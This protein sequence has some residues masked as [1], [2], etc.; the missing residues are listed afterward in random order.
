MKRITISI[1]AFTLITLLTSRVSFAQQNEETGKI[2]LPA[3]TPIKLVMLEQLYSQRNREGDE[4]LFMIEEDVEIMGK[5]YLVKGTPVLGRVVGS[6]QAKSWGRGG[7]IDIEITTIHPV[8]SMPIPLTGEAGERGGTDMAKSIGTTLILGVSVVG[9]LAGGKMTGKGAVIQPGTSVS[10]Y[11]AA[12]AEV[13]D[14]TADEMRQKVDDWFRDKTIKCTLNYAWGTRSTLGE[15][16]KKLGYSFDESKIEIE[17]MD[18][19]L[20]RITI[21]LQNE[22]S[23]IFILNPFEEPH[24]LKFI[25]LESEN[26]IAEMII[27]SVK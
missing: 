4:I 17:K 1:M 10:V 15:T 23:A 8:Y 26:E 3:G 13:M 24:A 19:Y 27:K 14:I 25:T 21:P 20:Y 6:K 2:I 7:S 11:S 22:Q 9:L 16:I 12:D 5:V 18:N